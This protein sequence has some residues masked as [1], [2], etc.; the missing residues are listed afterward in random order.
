[1]RSSAYTRKCVFLPVIWRQTNDAAA[2][3]A[4][5]EDLLFEIKRNKVRTQHW[6]PK[7]CGKC[8]KKFLIL[9]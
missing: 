4:D 6:E 9:K 1:M 8:P 7:E 2:L 5:M 3:M